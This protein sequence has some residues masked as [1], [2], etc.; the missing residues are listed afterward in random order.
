MKYFLLAIA[1]WFSGEAVAQQAV[2]R[3]KVSDAAT[4]EVLPGVNIIYGQ[5]KGVTTDKDG[6]FEIYGIEGRVNLQFRYVGYNIVSRTVDVSRNKSLQ[7]DIKLSL[8]Q[9]LLDELVVSASRYEQRLSDVIVSMDVLKPTA[10][11]N[12]HTLTIET[13]L[14]QV[15]G[16][17]IL[18]GQASIRGGNG[19]SYGVGSRVLLLLDG[20]PMLTGGGGEAKW[21]FVPLEN[22]GQVE[23]IK[24]ASSVL[25]GSSALNGV[26]N[27]RT[28]YPTK[29]H[30][31][32][33]FFYSGLYG[34]PSREEIAWWGD[35]KQFYYGS[36]FTHSQM[37]GGLDIVVGGNLAE[38]KGYREKENEKYSRFNLNTRYRFRKIKG[39]DAGVNTNYMR[40]KGGNFLIWLN[41][42][43]GVYQP[44]PVVDQ[45]YDNTRFNI[46][47]FI[48]YS[49]DP[50]QRY[51]LRSRIFMVSFDTDTMHNYDNT[52]L[53][54]YQYLKKFNN[55]LSITSGVG[56]TFVTSNS[57]L[58][59]G[60][61]HDASNQSIYLQVDKRWKNLTAA[62]GGRYELHRIDKIKENSGP[63]FRAGL[64]FQAG[65]YTFLRA[66]YGQG[67]RYPA[68]AEKFAFTKVGALRIFSNDT[69]R[70]EQGWN[71]EIGLKQGFSFGK[72]KGYLDMALFWNEY[73]NMIEFTFGQ[74]YPAHIT[75]PT[76]F[77]FFNYTGFKAYNIG[78]ARI[79]GFEITL[80][81][82]GSIGELPVEFSTGYTYTDPVEKNFDPAKSTATTTKNILKY[83]FY[84]SAKAGINISYRKFST[85]ITM[86][87]HSYMINIDK[88]FE[89]S[90]RFSNGIPYGIIVP[91]M[92]A[93]RAANNKGD[94]LF[95]WRLTWQPI[96]LTR[97]SFII[98]NLFNREY[99]TRPAD[100]GP[101]RV[102]AIQASVR[103]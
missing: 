99:M 9:H 71:A 58:F 34:T 86:D 19:Y 46:D 43:D 20:L 82:Q 87:Y 38:D 59:K 22:L 53:I 39:L 98:N 61:K 70:P 67:F 49:P 93:Y 32:Q 28:A 84:H 45:S 21:D 1:F 26:I 76:I 31:T 24:G 27:V 63:L 51:S 89:D 23:V 54:D 33:L 94:V 25:Y 41:G 85:G 90:L 16:V 50:S 8:Q 35:K 88:A 52:Y 37:V 14:Q 5:D 69:L 56:S 96:A 11:E 74:H 91:G 72:T 68:I 102:F 78:Q 75:R 6:L 81:G 42:T 103:F 17:T 30:E 10:I 64:N 3:G 13:A 95:N 7:L 4:G 12:M 40:K 18:D 66:S 100:V 62:L 15:P 57:S 101:P 97:F 73:T 55:Q 79:T 44:A 77:D 83:R 48:N 65:K 92:K 29:K 47:P 36:R 80:N 60:T 2:V